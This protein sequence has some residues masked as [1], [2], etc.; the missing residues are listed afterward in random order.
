MAHWSD[1]SLRGW[2]SFL[3]F[4]HIGLCLRSFFDPNF[5]FGKIFHTNIHKETVFIRYFGCYSI[6]QAFILI[7]SAIHLYVLP[8]QTIT[9]FLLILFII[10]ILLESF[11]YCTLDFYGG[12][13]LPFMMSII[14]L[15]WLILF[16][17]VWKPWLRVEINEDIVKSGLLH[18]GHQ[19]HHHNKRNKS[20]HR[21]PDRMSSSNHKYGKIH[22]D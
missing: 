11:Y 2:L 14:S 6:S 3:A 15:I 22:S 8:L 21:Y 13:L 5:L 7:Q 10:L 4:M 20:Q 12:T 18:S 16:H 19:S 17:F 9:I 1:Y